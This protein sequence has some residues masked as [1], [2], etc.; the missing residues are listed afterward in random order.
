VEELVRLTDGLLQLVFPA[1]DDVLLAHVR[2]EGVGHE[3]VRFRVRGIRLVAAREPGVEAAADG[4]VGD[5][6]DVPGR[7]HDDPLASGVGAPAHGNDARNR[8]HIGQYLGRAAP[9]GLVDHDLLGPLAGH[10]RGI[11]FQELFLDPFRIELLE[12]VIVR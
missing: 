2:G 11:L 8:P 3:V 6:H 10:L 1:E 9:L 4:A 7:A 12:S 5:L